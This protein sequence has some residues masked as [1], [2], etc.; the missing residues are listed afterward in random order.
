[1]LPIS[2]ELLQNAAILTFATLKRAK[3][4]D[5]IGIIN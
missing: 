5:G 2:H 3:A 1:M 4:I